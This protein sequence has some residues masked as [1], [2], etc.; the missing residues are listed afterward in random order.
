MARPNRIQIM[1]E[2][3]GAPFS[4]WRILA[5]HTVTGGTLYTCNDKSA[6]V[7]ARQAYTARG[8]WVI[9]DTPT[10]EYFTD[11]QTA[12]ETAH[13]RAVKASREAHGAYI[14]ASDEAH[15]AAHALRDYTLSKG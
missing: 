7:V 1:G 13:N 5:D 12:L 9:I 14:K 4:A 11:Q 10:G 6:H 2:R 8:S 3:A 15:K